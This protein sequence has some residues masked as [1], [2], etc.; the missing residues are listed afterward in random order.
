M[1]LELFQ[2]GQRISYVVLSLAKNN[3][4]IRGYSAVVI[5]G[6]THKYN[7]VFISLS[8]SMT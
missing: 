4:D 5:T 2:N 3:T 6:I 8:V 7:L 1:L